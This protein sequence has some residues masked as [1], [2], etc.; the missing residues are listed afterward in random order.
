MSDSEESGPEAGDWVKYP[1]GDP[2]EKKKLGQRASRNNG[3][4]TR[5]S[6]EI[7]GTTWK[8]KRPVKYYAHKGKDNRNGKTVLQYKHASASAGNAVAVSGTGLYEYAGAKSS[9]AETSASAELLDGFIEVG[10]SAEAASTRSS[11]TVTVLGVHAE[12]KASGAEA[13]TSAALLDG[14]IKV[15]ASAEAATAK[16]SATATV[17]GVHAEADA[18]VA[19]VAAGM[20]HTPLQ[21]EAS[22]LGAG[23]TAGVSWKYAGASAGAHLAEA[24]AGPFGVRAGVKF[25]AGVRN[26]VPEVDLGPVTVPCCVM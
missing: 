15:G 24:R 3:N 5:K 20:S 9:G 11:T 16:A 1:K 21:A 12:A 6:T 4:Y 7:I 2:A 13:S 8:H 22:V 10:A 23:A 19:G 17:L 25:G 18:K 14:V 26:G